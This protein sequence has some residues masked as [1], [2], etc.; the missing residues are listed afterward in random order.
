MPLNSGM[1]QVYLSFSRIWGIVSF[2]YGLCRLRK[3]HG[4]HNISR[5]ALS[6]CLAVIQKF[7]STHSNQPIEQLWP[8]LDA[9]AFSIAI[10]EIH[11][12]ATALEMDVDDINK[13]FRDP[14]FA[15][16]VPTTSTLQGRHWRSFCA[17][18]LKCHSLVRIQVQYPSM[19]TSK[20]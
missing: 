9:S 2:C 18:S 4:K 3:L 6:S 12:M 11:N 1:C 5:Q 20:P 16:K 15:L 17:Q 19:G 8:R 7:F 10:C 13:R 14:V